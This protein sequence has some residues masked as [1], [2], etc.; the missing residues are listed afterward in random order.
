ML[1]SGPTL[2]LPDVLSTAAETSETAE[3]AAATHGAREANDECSVVE[4]RAGEIVKRTVSPT[5]ATADAESAPIDR[6]GEKTSDAE[7]EEFVPKTT[8]AMETI[9]EI[10]GE[11]NTGA[12]PAAFLGS[13]PQTFVVEVKRLER[14]MQPTVGVITRRQGSHA[15]EP[16]EEQLDE[17]RVLSPHAEVIYCEVE[18]TQQ[19]KGSSSTCRMLEF[20]IG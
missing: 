3:P 17:P 6:S 14:R 11:V 10:S 1:S 7:A 4:V 15:D 16:L 5:S 20:K 12:R 9:E 19:V 2:A 18:D 13:E 8:E